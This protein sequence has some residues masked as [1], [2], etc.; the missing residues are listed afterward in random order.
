MV[1]SARDDKTSARVTP[2]E[3]VVNAALDVSTVS[4]GSP[5]E[6]KAAYIY[7]SASR[8]GMRQPVPGGKDHFM[9]LSHAAD[10]DVM[11]LKSQGEWS[12]PPQP[13]NY[14]ARLLF[15]STPRYNN[16]MTPRYLSA[17]ALRSQGLHV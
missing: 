10:V 3:M 5:P 4:A 12:R 9:S 7:R 17:M 15:M 13:G 16:D 1:L 2:R 11:R 8:V 6:T 14:T